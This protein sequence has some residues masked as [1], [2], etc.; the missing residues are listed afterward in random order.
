VG[1]RHAHGGPRNPP[2]RLVASPTLTARR[3]AITNSWTAPLAH[4][5]HSE[6]WAA[7]LAGILNLH[8]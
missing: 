6:G 4:E 7:M 2:H 8:Q 1:R 3:L 5:A